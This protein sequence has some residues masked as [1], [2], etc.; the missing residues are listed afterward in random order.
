MSRKVWRRL[1]GDEK[2]N[3]PTTYSIASEPLSY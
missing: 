1:R 2:K 3:D